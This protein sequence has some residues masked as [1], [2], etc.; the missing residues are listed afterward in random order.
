[1]IEGT[2]V[3]HEARYP[4]SVERVWRAISDQ[5]ELAE[6]LMP[7]NFEPVEGR[8]FWLDASPDFGTMDCEV[9]VVEPPHR[10][11][12][13]WTIQGD[14]TTVTFSLAADGEGTVLRVEHE[15]IPADKRPNFE[16]GWPEKFDDLERVLEQ[17]DA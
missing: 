3:V 4:H 9:L 12:C 8:T 7:N 1:V 2:T 16:G 17:E 6:W 13:R 14:S 15:A 10:L 5:A 11:R